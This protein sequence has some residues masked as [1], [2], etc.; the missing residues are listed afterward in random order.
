MLTETKDNE[1]LPEGMPGAKP[2]R[3]RMAARLRAPAVAAWLVTL[4]TLIPFVSLFVLATGDSSGVWPH[5]ARNV[6]P[7]A[8]SE[9][10]VL[11]AGVGAG[12]SLIGVTTAWL[13]SRYRFAGRDVLHW[14]LVLPMA[15]PT[16]LS[17]YCFLELLEFSGPLQQGLRTLLGYR[18]PAEYWF[19]EIRSLPGA[20]FAMTAV[21][22]PYVYLTSRLVFE[23]QGSAVIDTSRVLGVGGW[24]LFLRVAAPMARPAVAAGATLAMLEALNDI[25]AVEILGVRTLTFS[26]FDTWLNR[27]S[28]AGAAQIACVMLVFVAA[29]TAFERKARGDRRYAPKGSAGRPTSLVALSGLRSAAALVI[30]ALPPAIGFAAPVGVMAVYA[31]KRSDQLSD[32]ELHA[33]AFNSVTV[34]LLAAAVTVVAAF[35]IVAAQ[36]R[37]PGWLAALFFR[38]S[39]LGYAVPGSVL[40]IGTLFAFT[41]FD[42]ALD[43]YMRLH[44]GIATGLLVSGSAAIIVYAVAVRFLAIAHGS[45]ESG[46]SRLSGHLSMASRTL[47]KSEAQ[48]L[49]LVELPLLKRALATA[50]LFVFVDTMKELSATVLLRPFNFSTLATLVYERA[51]RALFEDSTVAA[52]AIVAIGIV[53]V[54]LLSRVQA[55]RPERG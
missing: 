40:A 48:T 52:L 8:L 11:I 44:F 16:Y 13:V 34:S 39:T 25:G 45:L 20:I 17:A 23:M 12:A 6:I 32:P 42:N 46:Y 35:A 1:I 27:S 22:Y 31:L 51:S 14:A 26:I 41:R 4:V 24:G 47:G 9:T 54:L 19:P 50:G 49:V 2:A 18:T 33:A 7:R 37:Q 5:L 10:I 29:L 30:C 38:V 28:L 21:L 53:P 15:I 36:Q 55:N 3:G 43:G